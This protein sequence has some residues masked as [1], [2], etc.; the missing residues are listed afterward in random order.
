MK[1]IIA[2]LMFFCFA[3]PVYADEL[4][5]V[6]K[7]P[8]GCYFNFKAD[9]TFSYINYK[10]K[11]GYSWKRAGEDKVV[12]T[13]SYIPSTGVKQKEYKIRLDG[14]RLLFD[15]GNQE[16]VFTRAGQ[17]VTVFTGEI[18]YRERIQLPPKVEVRYELYKNNEEV[19]FAMYAIPTEG[20]IPM[21]FSFD[22]IVSEQDNVYVNAAIYHENMP[23]FA[24]PGPVNIKEGKI[25][26]YKADQSMTE[27]KIAVPGKFSS[28]EGDTLYL[29]KNGLAILKKG[30][31]LS[32]AHWALVDRNHSIEIT[33]SG[34][35]PL[36]AVLQDENTLVFR[37]YN[38][39][40]MVPFKK[41][42]K[43]LFSIG[44]FYLHGNIV[45]RD[46]GLYFVD[47]VA[48]C[49]F[50]VQFPKLVYKS[51]KKDSFVKPCAVKMEVVL[52]RNVQGG[53][54]LYPLRADFD[55][56]EICTSLFRHTTLENTYWR[57]T[58]LNEKPVRTF[59]DQGE[60]HIIIRDTMLSGS[61]G[62]NNFFMPVQF[63]DHTIK[64]G[65]GGSTLMLCPQGDEQAREFIRVLQDVDSWQIKGSVLTLL[66]NNTVLA[67]F[68]AVYL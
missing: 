42:D 10:T 56:T 54:D 19:P 68:E 67:L 35:M 53:L 3:F 28:A 36:A 1:K 27:K 16:F 47:C 60:P 50:A 62:C 11:T 31:E 51:L 8:F 46:N 45:E 61:D 48:N 65:Q 17:D 18:F 58:R 40:N 20:K 15:N 6:W 38:D 22:C 26:L 7:T 44:K 33:Q 59:A 23:L 9:G 41:T 30:G 43:E 2:V 37:H 32:V 57:L 25:L 64:T 66:H 52:R 29:E 34:S 63:D 13:F 4:A 39:K 49:N 5:G 21:Q 24:T 12:I 55:D 14:D